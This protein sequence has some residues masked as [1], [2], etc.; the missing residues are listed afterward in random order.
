[1]YRVLADQGLVPAAAAPRPP[2]PAPLA[3]PG[4]G[5][6]APE[7]DLDLRFTHVTAAGWVAYAVLDVVSRK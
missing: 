5:R 1:V 3:D 6:V 7:P 4:L 2:T